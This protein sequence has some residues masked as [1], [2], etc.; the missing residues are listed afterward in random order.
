MRIPATQSD[1]EDYTGIAGLGLI[2][3]AIGR[4]G[5]DSL[6]SK[7][8]RGI[9]DADVLKSYLGLLSIGKTD[10]EAIEAQRKNPFFHTAL[11]I[12]RVP[13]A[14]RLRQRM[15]T[16]AMGYART[17][18]QANQQFLVNVGV[19][20]TPLSCGH[21]ALDMD[22]FPLDNSGTRKEGVGYTYKGFDGYG[23]MGA[24]LGQEGWCLT[25]ELKPGSE[26]GQLGFGFILDRVLPAA[27]QLTPLPLLVPC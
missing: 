5:L 17:T 6:L 10:F 14:A 18:D 4:T 1:T 27:R 15:D 13:S 8:V 2:G 21:V 12:G 23:V 19:P 22:L 25:N 16:Q 24:Y 9:V 20:V 11:A 7:P 3:L 26:N